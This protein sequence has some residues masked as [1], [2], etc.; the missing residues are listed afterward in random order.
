[1]EDMQKES[2]F[3]FSR[4]H[5]FHKTWYGQMRPKGNFQAY[6]QNNVWRETDKPEHHH[7]GELKSSLHNAVEMLFI[8]SNCELTGR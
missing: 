7:Y 5:K 4:R 2:L 8:S 3:A 6:V 1:M